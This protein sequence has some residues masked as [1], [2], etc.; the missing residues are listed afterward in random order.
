MRLTKGT[1]IKIHV[2]EEYYVYAQVLPKGNIVYF[3]AKYNLPIQNISDIDMSK[4][5]FVLGPSI[6]EAISTGR[7]RIRGKRPIN[8]E[9]QRLP[10]QF[11]QDA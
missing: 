8:P 10:L 3:D 6:D 11:I 2:H 1:I 5:L 4:V 9:L 7:W